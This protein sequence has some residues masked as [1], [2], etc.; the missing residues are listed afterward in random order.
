MGI[1]QDRLGVMI[2]LDEGS[3]SARMS[4]YES[5]IHEPPYAVVQKIATAL[6][7]PVP[8]LFCEDD[9]LASLILRFAQLTSEQRKGVLDF[10]QNISKVACP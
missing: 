10:A 7:V 4:R 5:G 3:A 8:Y 9:D 6:Q 2:G 1:A